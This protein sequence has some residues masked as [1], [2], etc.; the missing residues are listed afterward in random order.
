MLS[1]TREIPKPT[2]DYRVVR[3]D[4]KNNGQGEWGERRNNGTWVY[5]SYLHSPWRSSQCEGKLRKR[6]E[7]RL[8]RKGVMKE[9]H[10]AMY[11]QK[12]RK[13]LWAETGPRGW[14]RCHVLSRAAIP[15]AFSASVRRSE[16]SGERTQRSAERVGAGAHLMH[17]RLPSLT[18]LILQASFVD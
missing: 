7:K 15:Q 10:A 6:G 2:D 12:Q 5:P 8:G 18:F 4:Y 13:A 3:S 14:L 11:H 1:T 16:G 9:I 17:E